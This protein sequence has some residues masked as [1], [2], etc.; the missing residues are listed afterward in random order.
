M[1]VL[2]ALCYLP[3]FGSVLL[4]TLGGNVCIAA[5]KASIAI[6][7]TMAMIVAIFDCWRAIDPLAL[8]NVRAVPQ[9]S[10]N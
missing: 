6:W 2:L 9:T 5:D 3:C 8:A 7:G 4:S 10:R 1:Y